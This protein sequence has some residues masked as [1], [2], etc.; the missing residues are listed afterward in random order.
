MVSELK[1]LEGRRTKQDKYQS[2]G[3]GGGGGGRL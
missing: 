3:G 1:K 2:V